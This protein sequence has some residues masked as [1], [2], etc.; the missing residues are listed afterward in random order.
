MAETP[1]AIDPVRA[2]PT[3]LDLHSP[4][5]GK[6]LWFAVL[7]LLPVWG[8][9]IYRLGTLWQANPEY[10]YGW[11]VPALCLCLAWERWKSRPEPSS[12]QGRIG[13]VIATGFLMLVLLA[14]FLF[15]EVVPN[16]RMA[17]WV[18]GFSL[19][20]ITG[21]VLYLLGGR[22]WVNHFT[23]P[24]V[25]FLVAIPW[26]T[27]LE[28]PLIEVMAMANAVISTFVSNVMGMPAI[29]Q[30]IVIQTGAGTVGVEAACS[31]IRSLQASITIAL[32][33]GELFRYGFF[34]RI[35]FL[36]AGAFVAFVCNVVRTTYLVRLCDTSGPSAVTAGHD[37]AGFVIM[38][39]TFAGLLALAWILRGKGRHPH[40]GSDE[41]AIAREAEDLEPGGFEASQATPSLSRGTAL[42]SVCGIMVAGII[43][44]EL[45][46][47]AWFGSTE[48]LGQQAQTWT[49]IFPTNQPGYREIEIAKTTAEMLKYDEGRQLA[50]SD[51]SGRAWRMF[52]L[53]WLPARSLYRSAE[54]AVQARSHAPVVCLTSIG[55]VR[56]SGGEP[57]VAD[58]RGVKLLSTFERYSD[59]GSGVY[60]MALYWEPTAQSVLLGLRSGSRA[61][62]PVSQAVEALKRHDRGQGEKRVIKIASWG[63]ASDSEAEVELEKVVR[64]LVR[65]E[66]Q[67]TRS[68]VFGQ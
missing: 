44:F 39:T 21:C 4:P 58:Y 56:E 25:F 53:R 52:Y 49:P 12:V 5:L 24:V 50:W 7:A 14:A 55:M 67:D 54:A 62:S 36:V 28:A 18:A 51:S 43:G 11:I 34:R 22:K 9:S 30:G 29:R 46:C 63:M 16:W 66:A 15:L 47:Q 32:F 64:S 37:S 13:P 23:F 19:A 41:A 2:D 68:R 57:T 6:R 26:P 8:Y 40:A 60:V 35:F 33:L 61:R 59:K 10:S 48:R 1:Q 42:L 17:A 38:G 45:G 65:R 3:G 31:G 20:G 27:R